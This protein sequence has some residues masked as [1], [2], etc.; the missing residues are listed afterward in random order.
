MQLVQATCVCAARG[1]APSIDNEV[2]D[3]VS[4]LGETL[5]VHC[6]SVACAGRM[7]VDTNVCRPAADHALLP[8][9]TLAATGASGTAASCTPRHTLS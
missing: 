3:L 1:P 8:I 2:T 7:P 4:A 9:V 5:L 6:L